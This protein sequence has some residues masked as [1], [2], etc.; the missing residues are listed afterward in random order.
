MRFGGVPAEIDAGPVVLRRWSVD[1]V[2]VQMAAVNAS[3]EHLRPW[4]PWAATAATEQSSGEYLRDSVASFDAGTRFDFSIR[5]RV[6]DEV[7]GSC[8]LMARI[9]PGALEIGYWVAASRAGTGIG[10]AAA[11]ALV[12]TARRMDGVRRLEIH[13]DE[14]NLPSAAIPR[15][16]GFRLDRVE[17]REP[18]APGECDRS[19]IWI[20]DLS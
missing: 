10:T 12:R 20:L 14:G 6:T 15:K 7:V 16:L 17:A 2:A 18:T 3:L 8:G 4:M 19:Q 11:R 1:D 9:G 5:D 13:C